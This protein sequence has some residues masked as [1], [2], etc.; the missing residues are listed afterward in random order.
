MSRRPAAALCVA[1]RSSVRAALQCVAPDHCAGCDA[2]V[3]ADAIFCAECGP[4]AAVDPASLPDGIRV[5]GTYAPP[6]SSAIL[7]M[8]FGRRADLAYRLAPLLPLTEGD[9]APGTLVVPVPL[10]LLRLCERGFNPSA[11]MASCFARR[12]GATFAP[13]LLERLRHT[14]NQS[15]LPAR[16]RRSNVADAFTVRE[17]GAAG[18][19][20]VLVD[21]VVTTG[22]TIE[23]C[24]R[25][26]YAAGVVHVRVV[27][28]ARA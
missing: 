3:L 20:A 16:E 17:A 4:Y 5:A 21:D 24:R 9:I 6:L 26:L 19:H 7:R 12:A 11:L 28:L 2:P 10:H 1:L 25:A 8:K 23:A 14:P 18:R 22:S 27:A 13:R 15:S